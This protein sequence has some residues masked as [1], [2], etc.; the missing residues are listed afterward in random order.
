MD[1]NILD[2]PSEILNL[3]CAQ[4]ETLD[5]KKNFA[6]THPKLWDAFVDQSRK[7]VRSE[8]CFDSLGKLDEYVR[9]WDFI[10]E[11][12]GTS[13]RSIKNTADLVDSGDLIETAAKFCPNLKYIGF[14]ANRNNMRKLEEH[15]PKL[16]R[17][18]F[19][20]IRYDDY[21]NHQNNNLFE[22]LQSLTNL[23]S[24]DC[25]SALSNKNHSE[26]S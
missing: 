10:L 18:K 19:I 23:R 24:L 25:C 5:D 4:I 26:L 8:V 3:I 7:E 21:W 1:I 16:K 9:N 20:K 6:R 12:L 11:W 2:L 14:M 17:L 22:S 15:L 13:L